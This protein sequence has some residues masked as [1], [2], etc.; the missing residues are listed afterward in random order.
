M[1][2]REQLTAERKAA[3]P[4]AQRIR[5]ARLDAGLSQVEAARRIDVYPRTYT[6]WERGE[7]LGFIG[8]LDAIVKAFGTTP[9]AL[10][11]GLKMPELG[12]PDEL[13][14][15]M[16]LLLAEVQRLSAEVAELRAM[17]DGH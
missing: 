1:S 16:D 10:T 11:D 3:R 12:T 9:E 2:S 4:L 17:N 6:R 5:K 15:K 8:H 14:E 13:G 7:T